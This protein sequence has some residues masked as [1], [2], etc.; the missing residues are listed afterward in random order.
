M[1]SYAPYCSCIL[2]VAIL[3]FI[4]TFALDLNEW[5]IIYIVNR[6]CHVNKKEGEPKG[7]GSDQKIE[8]RQ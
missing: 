2:E 1:R 4:F 7:I 5:S 6:K 3:I 8:T